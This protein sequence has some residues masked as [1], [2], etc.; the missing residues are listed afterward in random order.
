MFRSRRSAL[1]R[2]LLRSRVGCTHG[3]DSGS[4]ADRESE[5][6]T[7]LKAAAN[8]FLKRLKEKQLE[9]LLEALE[10]RGGTHTNCVPISKGEL[11][12]R[13]VAPH[14]LC[15]Q[16]FR[17]PE[18]KHGSELKRLK[19]CCEISQQGDEES[20]GTVCCNPYHISRLC[21]PESPPPPYSRI[22]FERSKTQETEEDAPVTSPVEFGQSTETGNTPTERRQPYANSSGVDATNGN[23]RHWCHVAYWEHR[24]RVG[25]MYSVFT[26]SVNIF[27]DLPHGD[28]F[29]L[30]L[31]K[32]E[33]RPESVAKIRQ[34]ID[35]GLSMSR[36]EDGVW[37]YNRS[38]Y[39]LFVNSPS[40][41][42]RTFTVHKLSPGFSI[43]IY[44]HAKSKL[45][46]LM[47]RESEPP[48]GPVD[49][50]SI[51]ISFIKG[52][53]PHYSRQ[54]ITSCPCWIELIM[55]APPR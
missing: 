40:P 9:L 46:E 28:G 8:S 36:E 12:R 20:S 22:A 5:A 38:N 2:R 55:T 25:P 32:R 4:S 15:C 16:L 3:N 54:F 10:S 29:C 27:Y 1:V 45:L 11:G 31:L 39:A 30:G 19:F 52:W 41:H 34:K 42:S 23:R 48:D 33:G 35:Y 26:D 50:N 43:K 51:R 24:T 44:D 47:H 18:L 49:P 6:E 13:T 37:I 14:V 7:D 21:R 53:G 17:W